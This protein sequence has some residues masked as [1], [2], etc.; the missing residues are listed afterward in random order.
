MPIAETQTA[1]PSASAGSTPGAPEVN[2]PA[3]DA[4]QESDGGDSDTDFD[5]Q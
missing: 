5:P 4:A 3:H 2:E 1:E